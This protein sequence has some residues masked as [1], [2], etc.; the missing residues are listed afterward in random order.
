MDASPLRQHPG[1]SAYWWLAAIPVLVHAALLLLHSVNAP[2]LDDFS[3]GLVLLPQFYG[4][5][6]LWEKC[7]IL[8]SMYQNHRWGLLHGIYFAYHCIDFRSANL[9][10]FIPLLAL[11]WLWFRLFRHEP[12]APALLAIATALVF[13]LQAWTGLFWITASLAAIPVIP[14]ALLTCMLATRGDWRSLALAAGTAVIATFTNGNG[15]TLW[16]L[17]LAWLLYEVFTGRKTAVARSSAW[18]LCSAVFV[19]LYFSRTIL[20]HEIPG[21]NNM[22]DAAAKI[23]ANPVLFLHPSDF[24]GTLVELEGSLRCRSRTHRKATSSTACRSGRCTC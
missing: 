2:R 19:V 18:L 1:R 4:T 3:D 7:R 15:V 23:L 11:P 21:T 16:P 6:S 24:N 10:S 9:L 13:N 8:F 22:P 5:D 12:Y 17:V 20:D 14:L